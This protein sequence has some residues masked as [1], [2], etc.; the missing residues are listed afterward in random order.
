MTTPTSVLDEKLLERL[1]GAVRGDIVQPGDPDYDEAR[2]VYNAMHDKRPAI[3]VRAV[4]VGD[5]VATVDFAR[6]QDLLLAVRGGSHSV[7]GYGTCDGGV[8]LDLGRMRGIRVDPQARTA[9]A[10]G[11]CTW[12]DFNHATYAFGL[13][14]TGGIVST[15]GIGGLTTGGGMGYLARRCGLACDNLIS[16]DLVTADG[17]FVTCSQKQNADLLWAVRGGGGN[18]GVV[19]SFEYRLDPVS[20]ILGG[21]TFY[22]LDGDVMRRYRE[23]IAES[24]EKLGALLVVGLGPPLPFLPERWHGRPVCGVVTC[25]TGPETEDDRVRARLA[26]LGPI[27]GQHLGRMPYPV[28]NTLFDDLVPAGLFHYWK[29]TFSQSLPEGAIDAYVE[30]GATTP[31]LQSVTVVFPID[32]ACHRVGPEETAFTYRDADFA[33]ALSPS[34]PTRADCE[35]SVGWARAFA[36]ALEPHSMEGGYVNFMDH[37]D[38]DRVRANYRQN[39]DRL[40]AIKRRHDPANLFRLNHNIAP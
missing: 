7:T 38:Q 25:W 31:S 32:G 16:A 36:A 20:D 37:D 14:T 18:F 23:L 27:V 29:G 8:V 40:T 24:D 35:A 19:A 4:D 10:E 21:P 9:R 6:E 2:K 13:A 22:P 1:R 12:A 11:G 28:I 3:V 26:D 17:S 15:T 34:L 39:Y 33:T 30:Y 5:I